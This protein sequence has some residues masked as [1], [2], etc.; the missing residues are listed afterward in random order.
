MSECKCSKRYGHQVTQILARTV[1][2]NAVSYYALQ[3]IAAAISIH[4]SSQKKALKVCFKF[5]ALFSLSSGELHIS[6]VPQEANIHENIIMITKSCF[7]IFLTNLKEVSFRL[8]CFHLH[9][10]SPVLH[11]HRKLPDIKSIEF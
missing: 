10:S 2:S 3:N 9:N 7:P 8:L 11:D 1:C 6:L 5:Y 4:W